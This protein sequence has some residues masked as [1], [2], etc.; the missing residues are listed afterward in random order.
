MKVIAKMPKIGSEKSSERRSSIICWH[1]EGNSIRQ[2]SKKRNLSSSTVGYIVKKFKDE[3]LVNE[4]RK[5][6]GRP[7]KTTRQLDRIIV[8][9]IKKNKRETAARIA[10][11]INK[12]Y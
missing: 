12:N 4:N 3:G 5:R 10:S 2:I 9:S 6:R 7:R 11:D 1:K 8:G